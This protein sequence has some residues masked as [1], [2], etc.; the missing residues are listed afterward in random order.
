[1]ANPIASGTFSLAQ[2]Q[3]LT[4]SPNG[5]SDEVSAAGF[6]V[7]IANSNQYR[8]LFRGS[9]NTCRVDVLLPDT[10]TGLMGWFQ[11]IT[12]TAV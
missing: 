7:V 10:V 12:Y 9:D 8:V 3:S 5:P 4:G 1:M 2:L 6:I 11:A